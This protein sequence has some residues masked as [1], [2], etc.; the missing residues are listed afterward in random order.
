[1]L[2]GYMPNMND[3]EGRADTF[4]LRN[5]QPTCSPQCLTL[6]SDLRAFDRLLVRSRPGTGEMRL[7]PGPDAP[8]EAMEIVDLES[9][10]VS[11]GRLKPRGVTPVFPERF[12]R[13]DSAHRI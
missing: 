7:C 9:Y 1:V 2:V 10:I 8:R 12:C 5:H 13:F 6:R 3:L 4:G 11:P